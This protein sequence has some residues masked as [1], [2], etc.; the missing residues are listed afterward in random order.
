LPIPGNEANSFTAFSIN[1]EGKFISRN[2]EKL[3]Y[4][5]LNC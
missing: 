4:Y 3:N 2:S 1:F 5:F